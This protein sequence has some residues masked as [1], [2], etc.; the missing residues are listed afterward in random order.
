M[1]T[2]NKD[3]QAAFK[4]KM[5]E[6]G[7]RQISIWLNAGQEQALKAMLAGSNPAKDAESE[8]LATWAEQLAQERHQLDTRWNELDA[9]IAQTNL[10]RENLTKLQL[11]LHERE[12]Y[13]DKIDAAQASAQTALKPNAQR[14]AKLVELADRRALISQAMRFDDG[15]SGKEKSV[16]GL[17]VQADLAKKLTS[18]IKNARTR[19]IGFVQIA[20]GE[21]LVDDKQKPWGGYIRFGKAVISESEKSL[22]REASALLNRVESDVERAGHDVVKLH[23]QRAEE[24]RDRLRQ[25]EAALN[26]AL[27]AG[28]DRRGEI[29]FVAAQNRGQRGYGEWA[30]ILDALEGKGWKRD[31]SQALFRKALIDEKDSLCRRIAD[32]MESSG[33][34]ASELVAGIV[35][36]YRHSDIEE[37]YGAL[38]SKLAVLMVAEQ[39]EKS[40]KT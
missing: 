29:L 39:I 33:Q 15:I 8:R 13:F 11:V 21:K 1:A 38:A 5:R 6:A 37:K 10:Q 3:R 18:E 16:D 17:K 27:F 24:R 31:S 2:A 22:L 30:D 25:A 40:S 32:T 23:K 9:L 7:M 26:S 35:E 14:G 19:V 34:T 20:S 12:K 36:K 28:L 4:Q